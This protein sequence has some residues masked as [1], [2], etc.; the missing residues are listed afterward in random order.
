[1]DLW[2]HVAVGPQELSVGT[3]ALVLDAMG[4]AEV[5]DLDLAEAIEDDVLEFEV[6]VGDVLGVAVVQGAQEL[7]EEV[8]A[9]LFTELLTL[10]YEQ[11]E[12][13]LP[14]LHH[15]RV[16]HLDLGLPVL[17]GRDL[18]ILEDS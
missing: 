11:E 5:D 1:M 6:A 3:E 16:D 17:I 10:G 8:T 4:E 12:I 13:D 14:L 2:G 18:L 7:F 15:D 9:C